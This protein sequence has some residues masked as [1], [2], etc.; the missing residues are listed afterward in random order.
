VDRSISSTV[1][2]RALDHAFR[3][4]AGQVQD[5]SAPFVILGVA[6]AERTVRVEAWSPPGGP[7]VGTAAVCAIASITKPIVASAILQLVAEG[8]LGLGD[9]LRELLP[10]LLHDGRPK[11]TPWH[12]LGHTSGIE[13]VDLLPLAGA[14]GG[15]DT[16]IRRL[17]AA[18]QV[19]PPGT[20]FTYASGVY[21]LLALA[22]ESLDGVP[23]EASLRRRLFEP[24][25]M[26]STSFDP[27]PTGADRIAPVAFFPG[28]EADADTQLDAFAR[29]RA[30]GGGLWS[31]AGDLLRFGRTMLRGGELEGTRVLPPAFVELMVRE[32][33]VDGLGHQPDPLDV[34]HYALGWGRPGPSTPG[35]RA[36]FGHGG[37]TGTR[38]W[39]DPEADLVFVYLTGVWGYPI[40]PIDRVMNAVYAALR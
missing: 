11:V 25:A 30:A 21:D 33:T 12:V 5:G 35:S 18:R 28:S 32:V 19:A 10:E 39:I 36:A 22:L 2:G 15:R 17:C 6:T 7:R 37:A 3:I 24:L 40:E 9:D 13:D 27:R 16:V 29:L 8:R 31:T 23:I 14:G 34:H 20:R 1:D 4:A 26:S 38:L